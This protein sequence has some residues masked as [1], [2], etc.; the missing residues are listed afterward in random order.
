MAKQTIN[1]G[2]SGLVVRGKINDNFTEV[3]N[4]IPVNA[5]SSTRGIA[6]LYTTT[7]SNTDGSMHQDAITNAIN[8]IASGQQA[9]F[10]VTDIA[11]GAQGDG[12][13]VADGA[14][15]SGTAIVTSASALFTVTDVGKYIKVSGAAAAG[16]DLVTTILSYQS[17][18]QVTLSTNASTTV[19]GA[20]LIWGTDDTVA[21]QAAIQACFDN[22]GGEVRFP[23]TGINKV[24]IIAGPLITSVDGINPNCQIYIPKYNLST[25][26]EITIRMVGEVFTGSAI[27]ANA[28]VPITGGVILESTI[29]GSGTAPSVLGASFNSSG[30][31]GIVDFTLIDSYMKDLTIKVRSKT[32][33]THIAPSMTAFNLSKVASASIENCKAL[34]QSAMTGQSVEPTDS[35]V[36]GFDLPNRLNSAVL[37]CEVFQCGAYGFYN[38]FRVSDHAKFNSIQVSACLKGLVFKDADNNSVICVENYFCD[39]ARYPWS[40]EA[41]NTVLGSFYLENQGAGKWFDVDTIFYAPS[42]VTMYGHIYYNITTEPFTSSGT[43]LGQL[44]LIDTKTSYR[45]GYSNPYLMTGGKNVMIT[46]AEYGSFFSVVENNP[47]IYLDKG[48]SETVTDQ[49]FPVMIFGHGQTKIDGTLLDIVLINRSNA[50]ADK[51]A[52]QIDVNNDGTSDSC[53]LNLRVNAGS[54]PVNI[55]Q[56]RGTRINYSVPIVLPSYTVAGVPSASTSGAGAQIFVTNEAGGAVNAFSDGTNWRRVTDRAIIS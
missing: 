44:G 43:L 35:T 8:N 17:T 16:A 51:R 21:I 34:T 1:N 20:D 6:K 55:L 28:T 36:T 38:G 41:N 23:Y 5:S 47:L 7:G 32:G 11:Y 13:K 56:A 15:T 3:Y 39:G 2:E 10:A 19:S 12:Q 9:V 52:I 27:G 14:I 48:T 31:G 29:L 50:D 18:T 46:S 22:G 40:F 49:N 33:S 25:G 24:Y 54:G 42:G 45:Y 53:V 30:G 4:S 37:N 26:R